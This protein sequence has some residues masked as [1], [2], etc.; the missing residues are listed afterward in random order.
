MSIL[1]L[2]KILWNF[3]KPL[4]DIIG[5]FIKAAFNFIMDN[6][7]LIFISCFI[8]LI[9]ILILN[10]INDLRYYRINSEIIKYKAKLN[11]YD[12]S[13]EDESIKFD[14]SWGDDFE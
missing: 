14:E 1:D 4:F 12:P 8:I 6:S 13:E 7:L 5:N 11:S 3:I 2:F 9:I 10:F